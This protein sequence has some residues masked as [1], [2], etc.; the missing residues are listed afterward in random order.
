MYPSN[1]HTVLENQEFR[2]LFLD[3]TDKNA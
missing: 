2:S 3:V 1:L